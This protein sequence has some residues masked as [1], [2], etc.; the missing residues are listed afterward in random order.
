MCWVLG[1]VVLYLL[2]WVAAD[3]WKLLT[4]Q[5]KLSDSQ[6]E[7]RRAQRQ[8]AERDKLLETVVVQNAINEA[9]ICKAATEEA[10]RHDTA[11]MELLTEIGMDALRLAR[12]DRIIEAWK[13]YALGYEVLYEAVADSDAAGIENARA[14]ICAARE[15]LR[16]LGEYDA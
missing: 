2:A 4:A 10:I 12:A 7:T 16:S 3:H 1:A 8:V 6:A 13:S 9:A 15:A 11:E 14:A 5:D